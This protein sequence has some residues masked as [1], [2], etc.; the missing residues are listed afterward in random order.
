MPLPKSAFEATL[1][2]VVVRDGQPTWLLGGS[3]DGVMSAEWTGGNWTVRSGGKGGQK[4]LVAG[5]T[6]GP[7]SV[8]GVGYARVP[9]KETRPIASTVTPGGVGQLT[10]PDP[11]GPHSAF[12]DVLALPG[13]RAWA[14]GFRL[15]RGRSRALAMRKSGDSWTAADPPTNGKDG[16]LLG[17]ARSGSGPVWAVGWTE[18]PADTPRPFIARHDGSRWKFERGSELPAGAAVLTDV[19]FGGRAEGWTV[20]YLVADG[21]S[22]YEV[23]LERWNGKHWKRKAVPWAEE[24]SAIPRSVAVGDDGDLWVAG[25]ILA[26]DEDTSRG[27]IASRSSG[28]WRLRTLDIPNGVDSQVM[29]VAATKGGAVATGVIGSTSFLLETCRRGSAADVGLIG[30][31]SIGRRIGGRPATFDEQASAGSTRL[32]LA[33]A[34]GSKRPVRTTGFLVRDVAASLGLAE[35][36]E[37]WGASV[38]DFDADG[39]PDIFLN[40][41]NL[42]LPRLAMGGPDGFT[43]APDDAFGFTDRHGCDAAD[44]D[45][46]GSLDLFCVVGRARGKDIKTHELS[47]RPGFDDRELARDSRGLSDPL[48]RGRKVAFLRLD[49]DDYPEVFLT[50]DP[51]RVD[52]LPSTNRFFRNVE[53]RFV[54][55]RDVGLDR[56][57]GGDCLW[58][59]DIDGDGD[60]DLLHCTTMPDDG[61]PAGLRI[62]RNDA[63]ELSERSKELG[64]RP[65]MDVDVLMADV[66]GDGRPDLVQLSATALRISRRTDSGFRVIYETELSDAVA[67]AAGDASG[68][69]LADLYIVRA[70][71]GK[72]ER[73]RLFI[74][75][76]RGRSFT[77]VRIPYA[78]RGRGDDVIALDYDRN[79]L[80]DFLVLNGR[81]STGP[82]QLLASFPRE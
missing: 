64:V 19:E 6:R 53:G 14:V 39:W 34:A 7:R 32:L 74:N 15:D 76:G 28:E 5:D 23:V 44:I 26:D 27:F 58:A 30:F 42:D 55:A 69:G 38:A 68:D 11:A 48:G 47:L 41:H 24:I 10:V 35:N 1:F 77:S 12:A 59:G 3:R 51:E 71:S 22:R 65:M 4:G 17:L 33:A 31:R 79:G 62:Y 8:L 57:V 54:P 25:T 18:G 43:D 67:V 13:G 20:G 21:S 81:S 78:K 73:D 50:V 75:D 49:D 45:A 40:R 29:S 66:T 70:G 56:P 36:I 37:T 63:A 72:N 46:D 82:V 52:S 9:V 61:R 2:D 16:G 60:D 80:V